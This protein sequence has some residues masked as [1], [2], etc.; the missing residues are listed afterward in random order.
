M[1]SLPFYA[2]SQLSCRIDLFSSCIKSNISFTFR[3][4]AYTDRVSIRDIWKTAFFCKKIPMVHTYHTMYEDYVHYI[5]NG[6]IVTPAMAKE[7][8]KLFAIAPPLLL[9]LQK[10]QNIFRRIWCYKT[11]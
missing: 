11:Y 9:P 3:H 10:K 5:A 1:P 4:C 2:A 6:Y 7:F 8:S